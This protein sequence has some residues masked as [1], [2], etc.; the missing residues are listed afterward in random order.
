M[1]KAVIMLQSNKYF[2]YNYTKMTIAENGNRH[3]R[4]FK[5]TGFLLFL[6]YTFISAPVSAKDNIDQSK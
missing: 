2:G 5:L 4:N 6:K 1:V 3:F